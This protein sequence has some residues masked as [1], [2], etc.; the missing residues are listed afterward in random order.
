MVQSRELAN[1]LTCRSTLMDDMHKGVIVKNTFIDL[2]EYDDGGDSKRSCSL[3]R[4]WKPGSLACGHIPYGSA[5]PRD[6]SISSSTTAASLSSRDAGASDRGE[7]SDL[8]E[9]APAVSSSVSR[10]NPEAAVFS[11]P[12]GNSTPQ[13]ARANLSA[14]ARAFEPVVHQI[15]LIPTVMQEG[16][17]LRQEVLN[18]IA[19]ATFALQGSPNVSAVKVVTGT[20]HVNVIADVTGLQGVL[21]SRETLNLAKDALLGFTTGS[22]NTFILGYATSAP[23]KDLCETGFKCS[24]GVVTAEQQA[25][26]CWDTWQKGFCPR[27]A[28]CRWCH[29][30]ERDLTTVRF[31]LKKND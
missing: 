20:N 5:L 15:P 27:R 19:S 23:F 3:P 12:T 25:T 13:V 2:E 28:T 7:D 6:G 14:Q 18:A 24:I 4:M 30:E 31:I 17:H 22:Q 26:A 9:E 10:L 29:P 16:T 11:P 8:A 1:F 21:G